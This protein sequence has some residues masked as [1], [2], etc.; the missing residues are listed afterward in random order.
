MSHACVDCGRLLTEKE[1]H[2][3]GHTCNEC[4]GRVVAPERELTAEELRGEAERIA[5]NLERTGRYLAARI[6]LE[7][8]RRPRCSQDAF[9]VFATAF[10]ANLERNAK[11]GGYQ[12]Q[13]TADLW[14]AWQKAHGA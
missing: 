7:L 3:Y 14:R 5:G 12:Y 6:I 2:Y 13:Q 9:E 1:R 11:T 4:E 10:G 8:V